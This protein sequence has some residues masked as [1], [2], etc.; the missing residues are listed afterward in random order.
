LVRQYW[1]SAALLAGLAGLLAW[2]LFLPGFI[3]IADTGDFGRVAGWLC[4]APRDPPT[5][6]TFFQPDWVWSAK[7]FW[8][9]PYKSSETFLGWLAIQLV[10]ANYER[11]RFDIRWL[12]VLHVMLCLG[13]FAALLAALRNYPKRIQALVA[14]VPLLLLTDICYTS[15]LNSFYMDTV[16]FCSLV[17]MVGVAVRPARGGRAGEP[18]RH[19]SLQR[20]CS[21]RQNTARHLVLSPRPVSGAPAEPVSAA[22]AAALGRRRWSHLR[23]LHGAYGGPGIQGTGPVCC[24]TGLA[25]KVPLPCPTS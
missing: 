14:A 10:G 19:L 18:A 16:A 22:R 20:S 5:H 17:L 23:R 25:R 15:Y 21:S 3:G 8:D 6:F 7:N 13:G 11:A 4:L 12:A 9:S 1:L 24:S 2:Q